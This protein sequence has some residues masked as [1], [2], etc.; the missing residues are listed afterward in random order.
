MI[1]HIFW[2]TALVAV[3][4]A[5]TGM[6]AQGDPPLHHRFLLKDESRH[7]LHYID[8]SKPQD[9]WAIPLDRAARDIQ[10]IGQ[11]QVLVSHPEGY[12]V[13]DL[14]LQQEVKRLRDRRYAGTMTVRRLADGGTLLGGNAGGVRIF[15]LDRTDRLVRQ[16]IFPKLKALRLMRRTPEGNL[17]LGEEDGVSEVT[18]DSAAADGGREVRRLKL[19]RARN[20]YM[21][22]KS[23]EG[24][25]WISGGYARAWFE[26]RSDGRVEKQFEL[27]NLP[28]GLISHFFSGFQVLPNRHVVITHWTGHG[29]D[30]SRKGWQVVE[31]D[32]QGKIVWKWHDPKLAGSAHGIIVLD[33]LDTSRLHDDAGGIL[34]PVGR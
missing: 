18:F 5:A 26:M 29:A 1:R 27:A 33:Q 3:G 34:G 25:Y 7:L 23:P 8:E 24:T 20:A 13:Y 28:N 32:T 14:P 17:L 9:H 16:M 12:T 19:P 31:F 30:D 11:N 22:L 10:L 6:G 2:L 21:A 15:E 4:S